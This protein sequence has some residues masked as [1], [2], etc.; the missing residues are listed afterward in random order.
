MKLLT[1]CL[2]DKGEIN[3]TGDMTL[4]EA[5]I[6]ILALARSQ[7]IQKPP[8]SVEE[9]KDEPDATPNSNPN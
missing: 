8:E 3:A 4:E 1:I 7:G 6:I 2:G 5:A 9:K